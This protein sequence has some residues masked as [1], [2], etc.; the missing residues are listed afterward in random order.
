MDFLEKKSCNFYENRV[1][2]TVLTRFCNCLGCSADQQQESS[3]THQVMLL[4]HRRAASSC[5]GAS[6]D[7]QFRIPSP[8]PPPQSIMSA[9]EFD[10]IS[11]EKDDPDGDQEKHWDDT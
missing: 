9:E 7:A 8:P 4:H 11:V 6:G 3:S 10:R 1:N 5:F 2:F